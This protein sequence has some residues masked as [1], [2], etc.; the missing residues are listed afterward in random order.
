MKNLS[1]KEK[2]VALALWQVGF[3]GQHCLYCN[4]QWLDHKERHA[5][6]RLGLPPEEKDAL[7]KA[8]E[9]AGISRSKSLELIEREVT[10]LCC[11]TGRLVEVAAEH[12]P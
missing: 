5:E 10:W 3:S 12:V 7:V 8:L 1:D 9:Y 4:R 6:A 2:T 11:T